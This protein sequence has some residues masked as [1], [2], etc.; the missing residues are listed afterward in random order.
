MNAALVSYCYYCGGGGVVP[1]SSGGV[2]EA[3]GGMVE[4]G[5][6]GVSD[7]VGA[8]AGSVGIVDGAESAGGAVISALSSFLAQ[9]AASNRLV[10]ATANKA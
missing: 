1:V 10:A 5:A 9:P 7:G 8:G 6:G 2:V 3:S 4:S